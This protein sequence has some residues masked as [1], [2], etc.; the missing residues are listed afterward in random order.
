MIGDF[1]SWFEK[2][3][4]TEEELW[5]DFM[6]RNSIIYVDSHG[7]KKFDLGKML[8]FPEGREKMMKLIESLRT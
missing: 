3:P 2:K 4:K 1:K 7:C 8:T 5:F 6:V